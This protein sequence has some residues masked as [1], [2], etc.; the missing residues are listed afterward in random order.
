ML[1]GGGGGDRLQCGGFGAQRMP[2]TVDRGRG[3]FGGMEGSRLS[4]TTTQVSKPSR[5]GLP[6]PDDKHGYRAIT[7]ANRTKLYKILN[8]FLIYLD[9]K[10]LSRFTFYRTH[11]Y[12]WFLYIKIL[13]PW[14]G[15]ISKTTGNR[16]YR[17][18]KT[19]VTFLNPNKFKK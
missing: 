8:Y 13:K 16:G 5:P 19:A 7:V 6:F 9:L 3:S 17:R 1:C 12:R 15:R 10:R 11:G 18:R 4:T 14:C 2:W